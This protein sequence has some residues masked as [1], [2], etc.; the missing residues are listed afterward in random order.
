MLFGTSFCW[1][2]FKLKSNIQQI[3]PPDF[4]SLDHWLLQ[5]YRPQF[6]VNSIGQ[7]AQ[8]A[9]SLHPRQRICYYPNLLHGGYQAF[10]LDHLFADCCHPAVTAELKVSYSRPIPPDST[11]LLKVWPTKAN[12]R[13]IYM[14]GS[15]TPITQCQDKET[16]AVM[17]EALFILPKIL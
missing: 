17:A 11:L 6:D 1:G 2:F 14:S 16:P 9:L 12:G 5:G 4:A 7:K 15:I 10:L 3:F 13:K 8:V